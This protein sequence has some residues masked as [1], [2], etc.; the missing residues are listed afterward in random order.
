VVA[1]LDSYAAARGEPKDTVRAAAAAKKV[2]SY[3]NAGSGA[4]GVTSAD[5]AKPK[6]GDKKKNTTG[7]T[8]DPAHPPKP[9]RAQAPIIQP[10][11]GNN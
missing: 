1:K 8:A 10:P 6:P 3:A 7:A 2:E 11:P 5:Q 4:E 9:R